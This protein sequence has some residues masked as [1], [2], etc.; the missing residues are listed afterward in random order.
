MSKLRDLIF[1]L[2]TRRIAKADQKGQYL[3][4]EDFALLKGELAKKNR[5][6]DVV[7]RLSQNTKAIVMAG[8]RQL[9]RDRPHLVSPGG[10]AYPNRR[11][12]ACLRDM[13][14]LLR[15]IILSFL[16][17]DA[18]IMQV[19]CLDGLKETYYALGTP[20][21]YV[22]EAIEDMYAEAMRYLDYDGTVRPDSWEDP[23]S[24]NVSVADEY[25]GSTGL[26]N[27][28]DLYSELKTYFDIAKDGVT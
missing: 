15:Y 5:R 22:A 12:Q 19:R 10:N 14:F 20:N 21:E 8:S 25:D 7:R 9:F 26:P 27:C 13:E 3:K 6:F 18:S 11:N 28:S 1:D 4:P 16:C 24:W 2:Y 17:G 23:Y